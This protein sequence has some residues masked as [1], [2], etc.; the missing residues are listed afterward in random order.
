MLI[1]IEKIVVGTRLRGANP[2]TVAALAA[3]ISD[4]GLLHPV[5][6][7]EREVIHAGIA[8]PGWGI[9]AGLHR[10]EACRGLGMTVIPAHVVTL[11]D[12][13][14][15]IAECDENLCGP[16]L[17][18]AERS[19]FL[20]RRK[21]AYEALH[22]ETRAHV[23]GAHA[24]NKAQGNASANLAPAFTADTAAKTGQSERTIQRDIAR[25][26]K[27]DS[28]VL[29]SLRGSDIDTGRTLDALAAVPRDQQ[30]ARAREIAEQKASATKESRKADRDVVYTEAQR[31]AEWLKGLL[32]LG[33][34]RRLAEWIVMIKPSE[35]SAALLRDDAGPV[36]DKSDFGAR[37]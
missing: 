18:H 36:F 1:D 33:E 21:E 30:A 35:L 22:P 3:S 25:A 11:G 13:E 6:V 17:G 28:G 9:V 20:R 29:A 15:Q 14:R 2:E 37:V 26:D 19:M 7:Y 12:L 34:T 4:V 10:L 24:S 23:A 32:D 16:K 8:V 31:C 27:I 5:T